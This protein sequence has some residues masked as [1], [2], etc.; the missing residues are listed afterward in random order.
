MKKTLPRLRLDRETVRSL[1]PANLEVVAGGLR[2]DESCA[3]SC[4]P[5]TIWPRAACDSLLLTVC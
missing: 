2:T 1:T 3:N 4:D 5:N